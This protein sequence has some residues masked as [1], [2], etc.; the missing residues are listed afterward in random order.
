MQHVVT[1]FHILKFSPNLKKNLQLITYCT[2][3]L[4]NSFYFFFTLVLNR[5][6]G[7]ELTLFGGRLVCLI[8]HLLERELFLEQ[9]FIYMFF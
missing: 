9:S 5:Q 1:G 8:F 2:D 7:K 4:R 3:K 6:P